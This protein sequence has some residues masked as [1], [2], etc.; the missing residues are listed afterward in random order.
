LST[1]SRGSK[2]RAGPQDRRVPICRDVAFVSHGEVCL[3][4]QSANCEASPD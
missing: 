4:E 3:L 1:F 2:N